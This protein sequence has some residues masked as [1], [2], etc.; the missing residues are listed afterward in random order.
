[1]HRLALLLAVPIFAGI[2]PLAPPLWA[3]QQQAG[4]TPSQVAQLIEKLGSPS[5]ATRLRAHEKLQRMGLEAFDQLHAA[6]FHTD[7]EIAMA[8]RHLVSS[9]LVSWSKETDPAE[10]R[11]ILHEY[12]TQNEDERGSRIEMLSELSDRK[13]MVALVRLA[14]FETSLRL[15]RQSAL[16]L[17]QQPM[18]EDP[19][20]RKRRAQQLLDVLGSN[21][22]QAAQW[23]RV[24]SQ[25]LS[26]DG[27]SKQRWRALI[28][29]QRREIDSASSQHATRSSVLELVRAC[30]T[31][32]ADLGDTEEAIDLAG[33][34][35]DLIPPTSRDLIDA[36]SWAIDNNLHPFVL[37]LR[38]Q[39]QRMFDHQPVLLYG[40]AE[41]VKVAGDLEKA[42]RLANQALQI[43][44]LPQAPPEAQPDP[45]T[46]NND[47]GGSMSPKAM[48]ETAQAHREIG[49]K[50]E[51]RGLFH[52]AEREFRQI[53]D[54]MPVDSQPAA[55]T[56]VHLARMLGE[57]QRYDDAVAVLRPVTERIE[58][59]E[60]FK[61]R[62]YSISFDYNGVK[63]DEYYYEGLSL[64]EKGKLEAAKLLLQRAFR[65]NADNIDILI[66]MYRMDGDQSWKLKV[67]EMLSQ[68]VLRTEQEVRQAEI[69][70]RIG[71][72]LQLA[73]QLLGQELN[74]YAWLVSNTEGDYQKAL[75]YS[76]RSL[77]ISADSAKL[78]TCARCYFALGDYKNAVRMQRKALKTMPHSPPMVR[79]LAEFEAKLAEANAE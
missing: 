45:A 10:V 29:R 24:Y 58:K 25:D 49:Q 9:L 46:P 74:Q 65:M 26:G 37:E 40:A 18:S 64:I 5:Y 41:A 78:D 53:I 6:Q 13:G 17:M 4:D 30:A 68:A 15:S 12:G 60:K 57:L 67:Q 51:E 2:V 69:N 56:R 55:S 44:P 32:A 52:W 43:R 38:K 19:A 21:D 70:V 23:L 54:A 14:R 7:S 76:L 31:R 22:R 59:D 47:A 1:M 27:Y 20:I 66:S 34:H 79:Q 72:R 3:E 62:M 63:S 48:E 11:E 50:L 36:C 61:Q 35:L 71:G 73:N 8:S 28:D 16:R 75:R 39:H 77:E 33:A 42:N